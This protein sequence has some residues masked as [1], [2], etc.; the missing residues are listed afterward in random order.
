M[1]VTKR[2]A[3]IALSL[4]LSVSSVQYAFASGMTQRASVSDAG[5]GANGS[6]Y[7]PVL[8][9]D[10]RYV[11]FVSGATNLISNDNPGIGGVFIKDYQNGTVERVS[12]AWD[13]RQSEGSSR[14]QPAISDDGRYVAFTSSDPGMVPNDTNGTAIQPGTDVFLRDRIAQ[15]TVRVS[16]GDNGEQLNGISNYPSISSD[17][18]Y[19]AFWTF[20]SSY[21]SAYQPFGLHGVWEVRVYDLS[22]G[23]SER[24]SVSITGQP[25]GGYYGGSE[26]PGISDDGRFV[27]FWYETGHHITDVFVRDRLLQTTQRVTRGNSFSYR[28]SID[29]NGDHVVFDSVATNIIPGDTNNEQ[30]V[31]VF[32][33]TEQ[34][35]ERVSIT[36]DGMQAN[37]ASQVPSISSN[38]RYISFASLATNLVPGYATNPWQ[39]YVRDREAGTTK[40][41]SINNSEQA[42]DQGGVFSRISSDGQY[43]AYESDSTNLV[44]DDTNERTDIFVHAQ[45][46][47]F[48][49]YPYDDRTPPVVT[50]I[51]NDNVWHNQ[52]VTVTWSAT[53]NSGSATI[54]NQTTIT[55]EGASQVVVSALSCDPSNNCATGTATVS[56]DKTLPVLGIPTPHQAVLLFPGSV[57]V[58]ASVS[59]VL[60][61]IARTE[62]YVD[63]DP[64]L[65][66]G[67]AMNVVDGIARASVGVSGGPLSNH[68]VGIRTKDA[69]GNWSAVKTMTVRIIL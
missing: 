34:T 26:S 60:S 57:S 67:I 32:D 47:D 19:V 42:G 21:D 44:G 14:E 35:T 63:T 41:V 13:G 6:S 51:P 12:V 33:T 22:S 39:I 29:A 36:D 4:L 66:N 69:A 52:N 15:T 53:D 45:Y 11:A 9:A 55:S 40:I 5:A 2:V 17:G 49:P 65:G 25:A 27:T 56:I 23:A 24:S 1:K 16:V 58:S 31:F 54:P 48:P 10:G 46:G 61:G 68:T 64:G 28:A 7:A 62:F 8:S 38:G 30:D 37:S 59:D 50:G 20:N 3:L 18:R 43:I